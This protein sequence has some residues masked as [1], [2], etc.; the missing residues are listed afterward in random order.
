MYSVH[1][2]IL[3]ELINLHYFTYACVSLLGEK[4]TRVQETSLSLPAASVV[5]PSMVW[6]SALTAEFYMYFSLLIHCS[7]FGHPWVD[8]NGPSVSRDRDEGTLVLAYYRQGQ[9][10]KWTVHSCCSV[11]HHTESPTD[12]IYRNEHQINGNERQVKDLWKTVCVGWGTF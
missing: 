10:S 3:F 12:N 7:C 2:S 5:I 9:V 8:I 6:L 1:L 4:C 11:S